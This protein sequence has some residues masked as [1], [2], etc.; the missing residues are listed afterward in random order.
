MGASHDTVAV[1]VGPAPLV[2]PLTDRNQR[3]LVV[4]VDGGRRLLTLAD[5]FLLL[6][7]VLFSCM[8]DGLCSSA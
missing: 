6:L 3:I 5:F 4:V 2:S 7:L 1:S 8:V